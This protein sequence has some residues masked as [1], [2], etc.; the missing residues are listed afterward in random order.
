MSEVIQVH[1]ATGSHEAAQRLAQ[2]AV[3]AR[4][5]AGGQIIGPVESVFWHEGVFGIGQEWQVVL[6]SSSQRYQELESYLRDHHEWANPEIIAVPVVTGSEPYLAWVRRT[7]EAD[8][9]QG[10]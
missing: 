1:T 2:G 8:E 6:K 9:P 7:V 3:Q 4:L 5:A 10:A